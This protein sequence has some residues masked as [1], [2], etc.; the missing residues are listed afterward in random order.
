MPS[1]R[2]GTTAQGLQVTKCSSSLGLSVSLKR[3]VICTGGKGKKAGKS[4]KPGEKEGRDKKKGREE[5][6]ARK[7]RRE[8][9]KSKKKKNQGKKKKK[10]KDRSCR[11]L[12]SDLEIQSLR[13]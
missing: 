8:R 12:N 4:R 13:C 2:L 9:E 7:K 1:L 5:R 6:K 3:E 11:D 10:K